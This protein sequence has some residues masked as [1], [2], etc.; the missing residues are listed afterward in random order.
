[1]EGS[2]MIG[3]G[4]RVPG[5]PVIVD[6][7]ANAGFFSIFS[8]FRF[9]GARIFSYEPVPSNFRQL[10]RNAEMNP[11]ARICCFSEAVYGHSGHV[12]IS[13]DPD[14]SFT[15]AASVLEE[16]ETQ[17]RTIQVPCVTIPEIFN[18]NNLAKCDLMKIDCEGAE[19]EILYNCPEQY[20]KQI[21]QLAIEV[22]GGPGAK[23]NSEALEAYFSSMNFSTHSS[24][25]ML[26][27]WQE[28]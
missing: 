18:T 8:A 20:L 9:P 26:W 27:I 19:Y 16:A 5:N 14:D 15:T 24:G 17:G 23:E 2:Y 28:R 10:N 4:M 22:H 11:G 21:S 3:L 1:M 6:I 13:F 12:Q 7:G 25:N